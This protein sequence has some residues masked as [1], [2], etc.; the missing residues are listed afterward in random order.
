[1]RTVSSGAGPNPKLLPLRRPCPESSFSSEQQS[2]TVDSVREGFG[3]GD[4]S[5][6]FRNGFARSVNDQKELVAL[7]RY[8]IFQDA[9]LRNTNACQASSN[10]THPSDNGSSFQ[11]RNDP[12]NKRTRDED[13]TKTGDGKHR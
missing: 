12:C 2:F 6:R 1:M 9:V 4:D 8:V 7:K 5:L 10:C 11:T 3:S 13:W